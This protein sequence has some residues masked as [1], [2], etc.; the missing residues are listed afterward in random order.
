[1]DGLLALGFVALAAV[2]LVWRAVRTFRAPA[3][4]ACVGCSEG[5]EDGA[6]EP[7]VVTLELP[8]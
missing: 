8:E 5:S 6:S 3:G 1:V 4:G 2:Y 7:S